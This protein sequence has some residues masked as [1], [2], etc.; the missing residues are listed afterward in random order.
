VTTTYSYDPVSRL[1]SVLHKLASTTLDGATYTLD[2]AGNRTV[3]TPQ[4]AGTATNYGYDNI[5]Q[6]LS[7]QGGAASE[8]NTYDAVGNRLTSATGIYGYNTSNELTPSPTATY[9]YDNNGNTLTKTD[10]T[11]TTQYTWDFD[12]WLT[13]VTMPGSSGSITFKYDP[14]GRRIQKSFTQNSTTT[15]TNYL[16][17]GAN[18][19]EE[20]DSGGNLLARY[21]LTQTIDEPLAMLRTGTTSY[22]QADG[23]GSVTSLSNTAG[24][25]AQTYTLDSFG[26]Q[27]ASSGSVINPFRYT[28]RE[29]DSETN[30]YYYRARYYDP[31]TGRF[32][33]E[34]PM[35]LDGNGYA[36]V[37]N[38]PALKID[39][40]GWDGIVINYDYYPV[41][42]SEGFHIPI[43]NC[44]TGKI[45]APLGHGAAIAVDPKT[46]KTT[47]F[48]YGRY[49]GDFGKVR[50][51]YTPSVVIGDDG[52]PTQASLD[53]LYGY[54]SKHYGENSH[55]TATYYQ[56]ADNKKIIRFAKQR[57]NDK[58]RK[59]YNI[60]N[61]NC[62]TFAQDAINA[63]RH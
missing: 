22:Y 48:E 14:F 1:L 30:L 9:T 51:Q 8:S 56:D 39:P 4:P 29:F 50:G 7:A 53:N 20:V 32:I 59:P 38:N 34:D 35:F 12:N 43:C 26:N 33:S 62:K 49:G 63:G 6:L 2:S 27:T 25:V 44:D 5:Y 24:A 21:T 47:Y 17:D 54:I 57:M 19:L 36:Y 10:S 55:V 28:G 40:T 15:T 13:S 45:K 37:D 3:R 31:A 23:L 52:K 18:S 60:L 58:N 61:N 42:A 41:T 16:Y 46:G 11:G